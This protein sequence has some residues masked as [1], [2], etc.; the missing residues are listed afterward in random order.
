MT[1]DHEISRAKS[2]AIGKN[3]SHGAES[4]GMMDSPQNSSQSLLRVEEL[5]KHFPVQ[6]NI[7]EQL[8]WQDGRIRR[9]RQVV[10]AVNGVSLAI[11]KGETLALVGESGCGKSTLAKTVIG[12]HQ[13]TAG[14][15]YY[16]E[17][18]IGGLTGKQRL[19]YQRRIQIIFQDPFSSLN[20]RKTVMEIVG[21]PM[22]LH[23]ITDKAG[24]KDAV[25]D[26]LAQVG[27]DAAYASRYPH[28]FSGGQRQRIGIARALACRPNLVIGDEP[29]SALDVSI[30]AQILNLMMDLQE[31][32]D[33]T[34]LFVSHDLSVVKHIS[35]RVAVM[36]LGFI[37]ES[38][39]TEEIFN[40]PNHPYTQLLFSAI[41][42]LDKLYFD[43]A[44]GLAEG[45]VP[46]PIDLPS[47]CTFHPRCPHCMDRCLEQRPP[48]KEISPGRW[49]ACFLN[50]TA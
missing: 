43:E 10:H 13:P 25:L 33:L 36:Y 30:Q 6:K 32:F 11:D 9:V 34:Y 41:P 27:L 49:S 38:A 24:L 7:F 40:Q 17:D 21:R 19:P 29:I 2:E 45:E 35:T 16:G 5:S 31:K 28:Q 23:G 42:T 39:T 15:I 47:G 4:G 50:E 20:P 22:L 48:F 3:Q 8:K 18:E 1:R 46:T 14:R 44:A 37:V 26:I 12:L